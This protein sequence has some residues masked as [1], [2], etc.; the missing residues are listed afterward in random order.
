VAAQWIPL[1]NSNRAAVQSE[2]A[3]FGTAFPTATLWGNEDEAGDGYDVV[4]LGAAAPPVLDGAALQQRLDRP[5][6]AAVRAS[7][8]AVGLGSAPALL[9]SYAGHLADLHDWLA[10]AEINRDR[11]LRLQYLAGEARNSREG[12]AAYG[13]ML[14]LRRPSPAPGR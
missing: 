1:Y 8:A 7:L 9:G 5:D 11:N 14:A 13:E 12:R 10:A 6:H 2:L 4:V 3:T